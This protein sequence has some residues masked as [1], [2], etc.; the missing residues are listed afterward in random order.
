MAV[1]TSSNA[2]SVGEKIRN[3]KLLFNK[4]ELIVC[5]D[6]REVRAGKPEPDIFQVAM[7]RLNVDP[8]NCLVFED[9]GTMTHSL[10]HSIAHSLTQIL[11][12]S[13]THSLIAPVSGVLAARNAGVPR[14]QICAIPN[15]AVCAREDFEALTPLVIPE[16][17]AFDHRLF[18]YA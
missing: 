9:A 5:G 6:D 10:T 2:K 4:I 12:R 7:D 17:Q 16:F 14:A 3:H 11:T 15:L 1:A 8:S 18:N 13:L